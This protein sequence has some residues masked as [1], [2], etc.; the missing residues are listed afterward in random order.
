[1]GER[2]QFDLARRLR[3]NEGVSPSGSIYLPHGLYFRGKIAYANTF[4]GENGSGRAQD[5][6][7]G[8]IDAATES[9]WAICVSL[10]RRRESD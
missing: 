1:M 4:P 9:G 6:A 8:L 5:H 2:A 7:H 3:S 10:P